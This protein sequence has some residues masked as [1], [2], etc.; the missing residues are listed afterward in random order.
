MANI[1]TSLLR[2]LPWFAEHRDEQEE[3]TGTDEAAK[4]SE[5]RT[6]KPYRPKQRPDHWLP[7]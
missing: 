4:Q 2:E 6:P 1:F 5:A 3:D 7:S